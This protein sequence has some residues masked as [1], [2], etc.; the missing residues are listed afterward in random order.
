MRFFIY[1]AYPGCQLSFRLEVVKLLSDA[2]SWFH[3]DAF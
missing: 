2:S 1:L 3:A